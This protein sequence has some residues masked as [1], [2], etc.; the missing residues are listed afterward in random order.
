MTSLVFRSTS[1]LSV[2]NL[3]YPVEV[4]VNLNAVSRLEFPSITICNLNPIRKDVVKS[5]H[6][7][8]IEDVL[9]LDDTDMLY[10]DYMDDLK[11]M[12]EQGKRQ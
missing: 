5:G 2:V 6:F 9:E 10:D 3:S 12:W 7:K 4:K 1:I 8:L 11:D